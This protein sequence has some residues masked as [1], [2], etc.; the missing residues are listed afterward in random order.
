MTTPR[1]EQQDKPQQHGGLGMQEIVQPAPGDELRHHDGDGLVR[2]TLG[3]ELI[4]VLQQRFQEEA[5]GRIE[6]HEP[7]ALAPDFPLMPH[8]LCCFRIDRYVHRGY[9][10]GEH[11]RIPKRCQCSLMHRADRQN[12]PMPRHRRGLSEILQGEI[13]REPFVMII[14]GAQH[15]DEHRD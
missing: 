8:P 7:H 1:L 12:D 2:L 10:L 13:L 6:N 11:L 14:D 15:H 3:R 9:V 4:D 5:I